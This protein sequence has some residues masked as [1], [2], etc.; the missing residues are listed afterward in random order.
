LLRDET[1]A[2]TLRVVNL[3]P[4]STVVTVDREGEP[5]VGNLIDLGGVEQGPFSGT[6]SLRPWEILTLRLAD[7]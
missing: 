2:L 3:S 4:D 7:I 6:A 5:V 1:G